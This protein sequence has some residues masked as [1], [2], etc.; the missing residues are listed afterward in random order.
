MRA[1][2]RELEQQSEQ[3]RGR[4][5]QLGTLYRIDQRYEEAM[6][7]LTRAEAL[8]PQDPLVRQNI[9]AA[10][11]GMGQ[12]E[13][14]RELLE[15][16]V[17]DSPAYIDAHVLLATTYYRL[18]RKDDGDRERQIVEKLTADA[19]AKQP[20]PGPAVGAPPTA[21]PPDSRRE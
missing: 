9:A 17:K 3:L 13:R 12:A 7:Y 6:R 1:F 4:T 19:Q 15:V 11:L 20:A 10:H 2:R 21:A 16:V 14:A 5:Q 8:Q 18:K